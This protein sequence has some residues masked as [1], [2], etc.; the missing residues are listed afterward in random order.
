MAT[1]Q[2][3]GSST[4][5]SSST[6]NNGGTFTAAG[7]STSA[8]LS[9]QKSATEIVSAFGSVVYDG[10][11][12]DK[13]LSAGTF[14]YNN[15][16]PTGM[17]VSSTLSGTSNTFLRSGANDT[18][19]RRSIH[20]LEK[21]RTRRLTSAIRSNKWNKFTGEWDSGYPVVAVDNFW[22]IAASTGVA[23]STDQAAAPTMSI[24]GELVYKGGN[25]NP[26]LADY[27]AKTN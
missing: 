16:K 3:D 25:P 11:D 1:V 24:P 9:A 15:Q 2:T 23:T 6:Q 7:S 4:V 13:A 12:A 21:V 17:K 19:N 8:V 27:K 26:V 20:K 22:D 10:N 18:N 14:S 5:T